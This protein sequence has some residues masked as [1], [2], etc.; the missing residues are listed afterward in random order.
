MDNGSCLGI[1]GDI[2]F[3]KYPSSD[4]GCAIIC[5]GGGLEYAAESCCMIDKSTRQRAG[6]QMGGGNPIFCGFG[7]FS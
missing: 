2:S 6:N 5:G 3:S 4:G 1:A 7:S